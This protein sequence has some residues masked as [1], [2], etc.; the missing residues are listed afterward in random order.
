MKKKSSQ[1]TSSKQTPDNLF[2]LW[3]SLAFNL[4]VMQVLLYFFSHIFFF[5]LMDLYTEMAM[6]A[7]Q[8]TSVFSTAV[9]WV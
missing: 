8:L 3:E 5:S 4:F 2:L 7:G 9:M 1:S 6:K